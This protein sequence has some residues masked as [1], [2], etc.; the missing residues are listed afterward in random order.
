[1]PAQVIV[2]GVST[3]GPDAL[4][5]VDSPVAGGFVGSSPDRA[6]YAADLHIDA[7]GSPQ[8]KVCSA[9]EGM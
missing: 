6:A 4:A 5:Q 8:L 9:G 1:M 7:C 3:G 2:I